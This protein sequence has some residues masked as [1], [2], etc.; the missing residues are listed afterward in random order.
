MKNN[1][2]LAISLIFYLLVAKLSRNLAI[3]WFFASFVA[4]LDL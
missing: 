1:H 4:K 3:T 2:N